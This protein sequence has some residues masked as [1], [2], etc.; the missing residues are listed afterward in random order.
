MTYF[1]INTLKREIHFLY[2]SLPPKL[3]KVRISSQQFV[4]SDG[5]CHP[6]GQSTLTVLSLSRWRLPSLRKVNKLFLFTT[7]LLLTWSFAANS[8]EPTEILSM[9]NTL[10]SNTGLNTTYR[11]SFKSTG[12]H[13]SWAVSMT[14]LR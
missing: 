11:K 13:K 10:W 1:R 7:C 14:L 2:P 12:C 4:N 9:V 8:Q 3:G 5:C 6:I